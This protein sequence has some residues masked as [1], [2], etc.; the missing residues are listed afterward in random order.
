MNRFVSKRRVISIMLMSTIIAGACGCTDAGK[1]GSNGY[2]PYSYQFSD[3][4]SGLNPSPDKKKAIVNEY[5]GYL[6]DLSALPVSFTFEGKAY[7]G[8]DGSFKE[9]KRE[10]RDEGEKI[11]TDIVLKKEALEVEIDMAVYPNYCAY[12]WT[13]Y[14]TNTGNDRI[15]PINEVNSPEIISLTL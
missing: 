14:F 9:V 10:T 12:E 6:M 3:V 1:S 15:G 11:S 2:K 8:F 5:E 13:I 7:K 4:S